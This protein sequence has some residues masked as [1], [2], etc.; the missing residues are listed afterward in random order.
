VSL[1]IETIGPF[2]GVHPM[3]NIGAVALDK[4]KKVHGFFEGCLEEGPYQRNQKTWDEFWLANLKVWEYIEA[5]KE[6]IES[7]MPR[8]RAW[9]NSFQKQGFRPIIVAYPASFDWTFTAYYLAKYSEGNPLGFSDVIDVKSYASGMLKSTWKK[10]K[11]SAFPKAWFEKDL[12]HN[13]LAVADSLEQGCMFINM[14]HENAHPNDPHKPR[15]Q[16]SSELKQHLE[17]SGL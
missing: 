2:P 3:V 6:P 10:T 5:R 4:N 16:S 8:F 9:L 14:L 13:H 7:V 15:L 1:D 17:A 12:V 11:K